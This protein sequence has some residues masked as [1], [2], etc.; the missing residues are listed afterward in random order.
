MSIVSI[1]MLVLANHITRYLI[2][3]SD[4][5]LSPTSVPRLVYNF[6]DADKETE[7]RE[8]GAPRTSNLASGKALSAK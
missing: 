3:F 4:F 7:S 1:I 8:Y 5:P 2:T 6:C